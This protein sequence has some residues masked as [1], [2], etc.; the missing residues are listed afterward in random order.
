MPS[1]GRAAALGYLSYIQIL[2]RTSLENKV[3]ALSPVRGDR[4]CGEKSRTVQR[5]RGPREG[6]RIKNAGQDGPGEKEI[7]STDL[8]EVSAPERS[9]ADRGRA[10]Q[11]PCGEHARWWVCLGR[12]G[13]S[14]GSEAL[15]QLEQV[16]QK[17]VEP[18]RGNGGQIDRIPGHFKDL[19]LL[20]VRTTAGF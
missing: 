18:Q 7:L 6:G 14:P 20:S 17:W 13:T 4:R 19:D 12:W 2:W 1:S 3:V 10:E 11:R 9:T 15:E 5:G 8:Q 16:E